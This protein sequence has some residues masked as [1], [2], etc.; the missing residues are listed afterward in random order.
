VFACTSG[1]DQGDLAAA[2]QGRTFLSESVEGW[3]LVAGTEIRVT[4]GSELSAYAG[5]NH[6]SG[7]YS[8]EGNVLRM[9]GFGSTEIGC[10]AELHAQDQWI[11]EL[12]I[13][14]PTISLDEPQ[15]TLAADGDRLSMIDREIGSPDR[16]LVGTR[17][18]G[19]GIGDDNAISSLGVG[20]LTV[21]FGEDGRVEVFTGCQ[22]GQGAFTAGPTT[23]AFEGLGYDGAPC[24][25]PMREAAHDH[26]L[27]VLDGSPVSYEIEE[28][29]LTLRGG[30][31]VLLYREPE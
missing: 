1:T 18:V 28:K 7:P 8:I 3:E 12:L 22:M 9:Q 13:A 16:P 27:S 23:I 31:R 20:V 14:S 21:S 10:D 29:N 19:N 17:W 26:V 6:M 25:N 30:N 15:L 2:L 5:C 24:T 11:E 4:F